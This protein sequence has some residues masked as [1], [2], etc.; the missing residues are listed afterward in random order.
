MSLR[1]WLICTFLL[2]VNSIADNDRPKW[3]L[4]IG[5]GGI[6]LADYRGSKEYHGLTLP[7][8]YFEYHGEFLKADR[9][10]GTRGQLIRRDTVELNISVAF[11]PTHKADENPLREGMPALEPTFEIGTTFDINLTGDSLSHGWL[12][13]LPVRAV[14]AFDNS[15]LEYVG[16]LS[17]PQLSYRGRVNSWNIR[18]FSGPVL[19]D[20]AYHDVYYRV[21][22]EF[23]QPGRPAY[24][25]GGG[26]SG[27]ASGIS[28]TRRR[29]RFW[30]GAYLQYDNLSSAVFVDSPL[31]QTEH[32]FSVGLGFAWVFA[33]A[34]SDSD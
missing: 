5:L 20:N 16:G 19:A 7:F 29:G 30:A 27:F 9:E 8:P 2:P 4:G 26:Y 28:L 15:G 32:A 33:T 17:H 12:I 21:A 11:S 23:A 34:G 14:Y 22:P 25:A 6:A 31:V 18:A 3:E 10:D 24:D 13:R 1:F